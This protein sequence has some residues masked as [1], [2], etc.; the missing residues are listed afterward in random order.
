AR[1]GDAGRGFA[2]VAGEVRTL[3]GRS[4][5][6]AREI[7]GLINA[8][9]GSVEEGSKLVDESGEALQG[10]VQSVRKV[11]D[12]IAEMAAAG[13]EQ[14]QGIEQI[15]QAIASLDSTTQQNAALVEETAA[16]SQ[17]LESQATEMQQTVSHFKVS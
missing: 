17:R 14:A 10:I 13:T 8:S 4:A 12:I 1:A 3:A 5:E 7:K 9:L 15:N 6:A 16:A 11:S 2:V